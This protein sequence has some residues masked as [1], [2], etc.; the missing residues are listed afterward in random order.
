MRPYDSKNSFEYELE[1]FES[2]AILRFCDGRQGVCIVPIGR[3]GDGGRDIP[4][5]RNLSVSIVILFH[6]CFCSYFLE[7]V[8]RM[9]KAMVQLIDS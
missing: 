1:L 2:M 7:R 9:R 6:K 4:L 3:N 8:R 5:Q